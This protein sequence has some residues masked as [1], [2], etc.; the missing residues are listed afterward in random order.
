[1]ERRGFETFAAEGV[2]EAL[3][4]AQQEHPVFAVVDMRLEDGNGLDL[5][6]KLVEICPEIKRPH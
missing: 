6:P 2:Q 1:M 4:L 3:E 5:V